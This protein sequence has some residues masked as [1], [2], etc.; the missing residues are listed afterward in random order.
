MFFYPSGHQSPCNSLLLCPC[1]SPFTILP[2]SMYIF[3]LLIQQ[4]ILRS[5]LPDSLRF[6]SSCALKSTTLCLSFLITPHGS[7]LIELTHGHMVILIQLGLST[8]VS[9][10]NYGGDCSQVTVS[11]LC[12]NS[13]PP[14]WACWRGRHMCRGWHYWHPISAL[15]HKVL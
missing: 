14:Q 15:T 1:S 5:K 10:H 11:A 4:S 7:S 8:A 13:V 9:S 3:F 6:L 2:F 12:A